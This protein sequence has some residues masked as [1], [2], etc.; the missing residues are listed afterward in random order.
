M[1]IPD[2]NE[3]KSKADT[4]PVRALKSGGGAALPACAATL[5]EPLFGPERSTR[6]SVVSG[7]LLCIVETQPANAG[8]V[9]DKAPSNR[10]R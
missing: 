5:A 8:W 3:S 6:L 4:P 7:E 10:R 9:F 1:R 2:N